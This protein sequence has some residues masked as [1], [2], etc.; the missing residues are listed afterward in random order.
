MAEGK[1]RGYLTF[2]E[3]AATFEEVEL[4]KEQILELHAHLQENGVEIVAQRRSPA[5]TDRDQPGDGAQPAAARS[6]RST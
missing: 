4:T 5:R 2:E 6:P 3:I 1:E